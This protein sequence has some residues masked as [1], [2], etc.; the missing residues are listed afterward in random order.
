LVRKL[1]NEEIHRL[2]PDEMRKSEKHPIVVVLENIR[3]V[4]NVGSILRT[5][6]AMLVEHVWLTGYT[7][8]P[9]HRGIRKT[10]L[11]SERTVAWSA[12]EDTRSVLDALRRDGYTIAALEITD[13]PTH[14]SDVPPSAFPLAIVVGNEVDGVE[15][16]TL[17]EVD[18]ALEIPQYGSKQSLNVSVAFGIAASGL[19]EHHRRFSG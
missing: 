19:V 12:S 8:R 11:G 9:D 13:S 7:P 10:A 2:S 4:Y 1:T 15:P 18:L 6:D 14:V 5:C 3:S 17:K 16:D